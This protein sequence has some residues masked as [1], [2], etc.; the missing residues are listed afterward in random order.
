[1]K[2]EGQYVEGKRCGIGKMTLPNGEKYHGEASLR[3]QLLS[4]VEA[5][6]IARLPCRSAPAGTWEADRFHGDGTY[7]YKSGDI[8]SGGWLRGVRHGEGVLMYAADESQ[9]VGR[10]ERGGI[11]S[12]KWVL[13]DGTSWH[14]PF[15]RGKPLG[16]G[17]FYFPNGTMQEGEYVREGAT[18]GDADA[19][20]PEEGEEEGDEELKTVWKGGPVRPDNADAAEV[21]R[22]PI[23]LP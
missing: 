3:Q 16:R 18:A 5:A 23:R 21:T 4:L 22:A 7:Y 11:V 14:G 13:K 1:V 12:G 15:H 8:Y 17:V 6:T 9:L 10:W 19:P 20:P 2:Y